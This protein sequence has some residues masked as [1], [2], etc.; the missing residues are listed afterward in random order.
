MLTQLHERKTVF[1]YTRTQTYA[2]TILTLTNIS[3]PLLSVSTQAA[4][5][6]TSLMTSFCLANEVCC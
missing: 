3:P 2:Y 1:I 5:L 4:Q 6:Y